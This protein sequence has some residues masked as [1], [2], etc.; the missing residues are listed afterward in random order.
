M[1]RPFVTRFAR[2][3]LAAPLL[4]LLVSCIAEPTHPR[5]V[6]S[7]HAGAAALTATKSPV[8]SSV[9]ATTSSGAR[10]A[11]QTI[12][13][14]EPHRGTPAYKRDQWEHWI[15]EDRD[16]QDARQEVL[17]AES[18]QPVTFT[19]SNQCRVATGLWFDEYTGTTTTNPSKFDIDHFVPLENAHISGGW[20]WT[21]EQKK[22]YA[23]DL[24]HPE[25]LIAVLASANRSKSSHSP[26]EWKPSRKEYWCEYAVSWISVKNR[27]SLTVTVRERDALGSML[28]TCPVEGPPQ[29]AMPELD[30]GTWAHPALTQT[31][32]PSGD[33]YYATCAAAKAAGAARLRRGQPGYR[34]ALDRDND[35]IACE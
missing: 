35:G 7:A 21:T 32:Q 29:T 13:V 27:W 11:L 14:S 25:H 10:G 33:V 24:I 9:T 3:A 15:D 17:I 5:G 18:R 4:V 28:D 1:Q 20:G 8:S 22:A 30:T 19:S 23:N 6:T 34:A 16:C 26:D 31:P 2:L 12:T